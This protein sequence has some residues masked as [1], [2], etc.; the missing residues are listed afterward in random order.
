MA[1]SWQSAQAKVHR[2][3]FDNDQGSRALAGHA[4]EPGLAGGLDDASP[5]GLPAIAPPGDRTRRGRLSSRPWPPGGTF[6][7]PGPSP[8]ASRAVEGPGTLAKLIALAKLA[9]Q[10]AGILGFSLSFFMHLS[11]FLSLQAGPPGNLTFPDI[12][13]SKPYK[14][15]ISLHGL[16]EIGKRSV[17]EATSRKFLPISFK[18]DQFRAP[19]STIPCRRIDDRYPAL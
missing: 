12:F 7:D 14:T 15:Y 8:G 9:C 13:I 11:F 16:G 18:D 2:G 19:G 10:L 3:I 6:G 1:P 4:S 17:A 5:L